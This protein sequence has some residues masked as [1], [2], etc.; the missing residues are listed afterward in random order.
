MLDGDVAADV[1][2]AER[3][4]AGFDA[5]AKALVDT[6][7]LARLL[8][9]AESLASSKIEGLEVGGRR[10]LRAEAAKALGEESNDVTANEVLGNIQA[11]TW[12]LQT[13]HE[14]EDITVDVLLEVHRRLFAG[15]RIEQT[16]D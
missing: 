12:A 3:S 8:L 2:D 5:K 9:R 14:G 7:A 4:I 13:I 1:A 15:T 6:E 11:M 10:L 16:A